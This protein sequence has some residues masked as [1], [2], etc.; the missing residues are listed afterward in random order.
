MEFLYLFSILQI[1]FACDVIWIKAVVH[2]DRIV[3]DDIPS[4]AL[5]EV[6]LLKSQ[7]QTEVT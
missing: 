4:H 3:N 6:V 5:N 2:R 7:D 1:T